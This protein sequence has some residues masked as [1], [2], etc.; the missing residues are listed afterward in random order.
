MH[1]Y[2]HCPA[3]DDFYLVVCSH[4]GQV[5]K[6]G[7]F[8]KHC[9]RRHGPLTKMLGQPSTLSPLQQHLPGQPPSN[10]LHPRE[11]QKDGSLHEDGAPPSSAALPVHPHRPSKA[12][13]E[14]ARYCLRLFTFIS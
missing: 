6:P 8:E 9:E 14:A 5:V 3:H 1:I 10:L 13:R 12:Q 7:A 11:R 2:G 4:C